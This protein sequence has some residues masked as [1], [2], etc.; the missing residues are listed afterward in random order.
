MNQAI[1]SEKEA[2]VAQITDQF[3]NSQSA[4]VCEYRGL[5]VAEIT[6]LRRALRSEGV[7]LKVYKNTMVQRAVN[8]LGLNELDEAL[9]GPNAIAFSS[10]AT[11]PA[12]VLSKFAKNHE[13]LV[14]KSGLVEGKVVSLDTIKELA[15]LPNHDGMLSMFLSVLQAPVRSFACI[16]KAVADA[17]EDGTFKVAEV[18]EAKEEKVEEPVEETKTEEATEA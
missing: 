1:L 17:K 13:N 4:V 6:E 10:D 2:L 18:S 7:D 15:S 11:A 14:I 8:G 16:V 9:K 3:K 5:S 12:R